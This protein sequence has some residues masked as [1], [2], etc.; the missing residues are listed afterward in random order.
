MNELNETV[1]ETTQ[2]AVT[3]AATETEVTVAPDSAPVEVDAIQPIQE[4]WTPNFEKL[5]VMD[6]EFDWDEDIKKIVTKDN[7]D[8]L[9]EFHNKAYGLPFVKERYSQAKEENKRLKEV[10][11]NFTQVNQNIDYITTLLN[12]GDLHTFFKA[13]NI[14]DQTVM[15]YALDR[16]SYYELPAEQ[17]Q[18]YDKNIESR[19][20]LGV[21]EQ[22]NALLQQQVQQQAV[23]TRE[24]ELSSYLSKPEVQQVASEFDTK[25]GRP[26]A[27]R[28]EIIKRG[29][30]AFYHTQ[31]DI[32][33]D[34]AGNEVLNIFKNFINVGNAPQAIQPT[35]T[36]P[37][38][39]PIIPNIKSGSQSPA[40]KLPKN[41]AD[42]K[43]MAKQMEA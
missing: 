31:N 26:G 10:E 7:Y 37:K 17:K 1:V 6:K 32:S 16:A 38:D 9:K 39:K 14:P 19:Q 33:P 35:I 3:P 34:Q 25:L 36:N 23:N 20:M 4:T 21:Y 22:Q 5:K 12:K 28:E 41:I 42:L 11:Q 8:K 30:H 29:Q 43:E 24:Q 15:K 40:K 27:F 2:A 13:L 18:E